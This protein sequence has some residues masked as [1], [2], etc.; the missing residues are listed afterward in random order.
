[1]TIGYITSRFPKLTETF[2][3]YEIVAMERQGVA[4]T[5]YPLLLEKQRVTHPEVQSLNGRVR[6][7]PFLSPSVL[8]AVGHF[9]LRS[10]RALWGALAEVIR[11]T[12]GST[13]FFVGAIGIFPKAVRIAYEMER[14]G[15]THVHAHFA[16][17]PT[18][19]ALIVHRLTGIPFSFTAHGHDIHVERRMLRE[20]VDASAFAIMISEYNRRLVL[21]E[22][23]G[24][25]P[26]K[27]HVLHC[28]ADTAL[29]APEERSVPAGTLSIVC[30]GS[31]IEVKG[32]RH[33]IEACRLLRDRGVSIRCHLV[34]DGPGRDAITAQVREA[35]LERE[36]VWHGPL[37]RPAVARLMSEAD[38]VVQP[39][40]PTR[41]GSREG[42][43]VSLMEGM[44]CGLPAVAS[45]ISGIPELVD[46][47]GSGILVPPENPGALADALERIASDPELRRRMGRAA[48]AK[49]LESFDL[50]RNASRLAD[51]IREVP[52]PPAARRA[53][54]PATR[55][56]RRG[57]RA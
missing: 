28:G 9:A 47:G 34:G 33:L 38:V 41:R 18:V 32:H 4:T 15:V 52:R 31:F 55:R 53:P 57:A 8:A 20:K 45:R 10:P 54:S 14:K 36:I 44:S 35:G 30:V 43:P 13:N 46:D 16:N 21:Q 56:P 48:R 42:I 2:V 49:V 1:M 5:L 51:L 19:A 39:S 29:F 11:G 37:P 25:D 3:L 6:F 40:V 27:L 17:H 50:S 26:D 12:W 7:H 23:P 22:C 24:T